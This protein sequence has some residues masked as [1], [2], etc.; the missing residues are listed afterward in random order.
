MAQLYTVKIQQ[1][2]CLAA[3][4]QRVPQPPHHPIIPLHAPPS[5]PA[6]GAPEEG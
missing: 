5:P 1:V 2:H 4:L 3:W 6:R